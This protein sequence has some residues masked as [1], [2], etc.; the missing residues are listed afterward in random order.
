MVAISDDTAASLL[1]RRVSHE[2]ETMRRVAAALSRSLAQEG[3][4]DDLYDAL[5]DVLTAPPQADTVADGPVRCTAHSVLSRLGLP[6]RP[7]RRRLRA[8]SMPPEEVARLG[9]RFRRATNQLVQVL[10]LR[11]VPYPTEEMRHLLAVRDE[12]PKPDQG[13]CHLRRFALALL[14]LFDLMGD[15]PS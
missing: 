13:V 15:D 10:P 9:D 12:H 5:E 11:V 1:N 7:P 2:V 4:G 6:P 8:A 3:F 14:T